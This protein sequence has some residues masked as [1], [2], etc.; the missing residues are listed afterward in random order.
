SFVAATA[1]LSLAAAAPLEKRALSD[2]DVAVLQLAH[3]LEN[4]EYTLYSGGYDN[5]TDAQ[6]TAAGFPA[7][8]RDGVGLTAQ[9][10]AIHRDTLASVL[11]SN[12]QMPLPACTYSFPYS[13]P[14]TF[15]SLANMITTVGIGA[16]L[17]GALDLMDSP[18][19]LTTASSI[20]TVEARHDSFL[21]AGLGASPFPTPF[22]TS[23]T[24]L[25]AYNLAHMFVVSCPQE[26]P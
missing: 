15:V 24:A 9:Q 21:R 16:Y 23:L 13:D 2:N 11:S 17:G 7:G 14:K 25:W 20:L 22:D 5:F 4:L 8:F 3:Y 1:L 26:L 18:D 10:E 19:L 6:Y 12:G